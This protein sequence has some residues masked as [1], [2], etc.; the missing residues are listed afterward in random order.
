[1]PRRAAVGR[2]DPAD[3]WVESFQAGTGREECFRRLFDRYS[4]HLYGFF[5]KRGFPP[6][7]CE[8]LVQDTFLAVH[9]G[10]AGFRREVPFRI[11]L[12]E[13][14]ANAFR[15]ELRRG[16][17]Q[18]RDG[19]EE[20]LDAGDGDGEGEPTAEGEPPESRPAPTAVR[21]ILGRER[22]RAI[23]AGLEEMPPR[24]RRCAVLGWYHGCSNRE[25]A[26]LLGISPQTVKVQQFR[27]RK[28]LLE[29]L[30]HLLEG[31]GEGR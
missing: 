31:G 9:R 21:R 10:L 7:R 14:A 6:D 1:L 23:A 30:G 26:E 15:K 27:A 19:R 29:Q 28:K 25:I 8:D 18:K 12:F 11:W 22:L 20:P 4:S 2:I 13:L 24:M 3:E 17:A 16:S 5:R